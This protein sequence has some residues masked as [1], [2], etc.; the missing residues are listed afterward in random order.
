M[1]IQ[2][3]AVI[4][5]EGGEEPGDDQPISKMMRRMRD[6]FAIRLI[7][8]LQG[9]E[10]ADVIV[11]TNREPIQRYCIQHSISWYRTETYEDGTFPYLHTLKRVCQDVAASHQAA[12]VLGGTALP[13]ADRKNLQP[14]IEQLARSV[15]SVWANNPVSPDV[16]G[17]N[18]VETVF[19]LTDVDTDNELAAAFR[20]QAGLPF[21]L[22]RRDLQTTYDLDTPIDMLLASRYLERSGTGDRNGAF[23]PTW[24]DSRWTT[25]VNQTIAAW[26]QRIAEMPLPTITLIGRVSPQTVEFLNEHLRARVRVYSEERGMKGLRRDREGKVWSLVADWFERFDRYEEAFACLAR[27][28][29][30][31]VMDTRVWMAHQKRLEMDSGN[32]E[33]TEEDRFASDLLLDSHIRHEKLRNFTYA[34][35]TCP[36]PVL[37]GG[38]G[39]VNQGVQLLARTLLERRAVTVTK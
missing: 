8:T 24:L 36:V 19:Q 13:L 35:R 33:F 10:G 32:G 20:D 23:S 11:C 16:V 27:E 9:C 28:S 29:D 22:W 5:M 34:A 26:E 38:F 1:K 31:I 4:I 25:L 12:M 39:L 18:P 3:V 14:M 17:W 30:G 21:Y 7:Q 37:L 2:P 6:A 15:P